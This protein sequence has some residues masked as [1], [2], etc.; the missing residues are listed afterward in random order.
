MK[1]KLIDVFPDDFINEG[2]FTQLEEIGVPWSLTV[3]KDSLNM[4][5]YGNRSGNK[6]ISILLERILK[7]KE[8]LEINEREKIARLIKEKYSLSWENAWNAMIA[9]Y[10]PIHNYDR[11]ENETINETNN[12][13]KEGTDNK[14]IDRTGTITNQETNTGNITTS[15]TGD[16]TVKNTG[17]ETNRGDNSNTTDNSSGLYGFNSATGVD[18]DYSN[19]NNKGTENNTLTLDTSNKTEYNSTNKEER[20]LSNNETQTNDLHDTENNTIKETTK[21]DGK[22]IRKLEVSGNIGVSTSQQM[23]ESELKL[24]FDWNYFELIYRD[25]DKELTSTFN[26]DVLN[27]EV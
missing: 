5:Y 4:D 19:S 6:S 14:T 3:H 8:K 20:N 22:T 11:L 26:E 10:N 13:T 16:D 25:I 18:S 24:R 27:L 15:K 12:G 9:E 17:T 2:I 21:D 1:K 23:I 7:D